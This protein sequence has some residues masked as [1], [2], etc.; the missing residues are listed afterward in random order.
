[1]EASASHPSRCNG[2]EGFVVLGVTFASGDMSGGR[3][4]QKLRRIESHGCAA[5]AARSDSR[6]TMTQQP[7]DFS[8]AHDF[9]RQGIAASRKGLSDDAT[10]AVDQAPDMLAARVQLSLLWLTYAG[11]RRSL[12]PCG[13]LSTGVSAGLLLMPLSEGCPRVPVRSARYC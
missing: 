1:M 7:D 10:L 5:R 12:C 11:F 13:P 2:A 9:L 4:R 3:H 6:T 8:V